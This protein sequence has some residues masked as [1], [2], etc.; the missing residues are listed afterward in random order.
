MYY[1]HVLVT[2]HSIV[3]VYV[4][5]VVNIVIIMFGITLIGACSLTVLLTVVFC[6]GF[7]RLTKMNRPIN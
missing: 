5:C 2:K 7:F 3:A 1:I 6:L 4:L